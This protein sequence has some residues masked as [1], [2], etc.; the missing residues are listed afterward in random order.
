MVGNEEREHTHAQPRWLSVAQKGSAQK[1]GKIVY[2]RS[3]HTTR[4]TKGRYCDQGK[5]YHKARSR[6]APDGQSAQDIWLGMGRLCEQLDHDL[7][8]ETKELGRRKK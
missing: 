1:V 7:Y 3:L 5:V 8:A 6:T 2:D 4:H